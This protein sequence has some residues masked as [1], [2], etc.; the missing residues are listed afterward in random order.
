MQIF[1][2][3]QALQNQ[4]FELKAQ[5]KLI[6]FVPTMG[7]LHAGHLQLI[8][9][10]K[11]SCDVVVCSI[12]VNP[13]Q[14]NDLKDLERYPRNE[15]RDLAL[16]KEKNCDLVFLPSDDLMYQ[17][18]PK[19]K[20]FFPE[21]ENS[22]EGSHRPGH[23]QGVALVVSKLFHIVQAHT[24][25]FGQKDLQQYTIIRQLVAD[26]SFP[27]QLVRVDTVRE[28][29][30]LAMSSRNQR[31]SDHGKELAAQLFTGLHLAKKLILEKRDISYIK[32]EIDFFFSNFAAI[33]LE[34]F[35]LVHEQDLTP[36]AEISENKVYAA[37]IAANIEEVRLIDNIIIHT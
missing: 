7:A 9:E 29:S 22:M 14:F 37:C 3:I 21:L 5:G 33:R 25:F 35:E 26:L 19:L 6:G 28:E 10:A 34:Y 1:R 18:P 13:T 2:E 8:S 23:F 24:A 27:I 17:A 36:A 16:L 4:I 31:L 12:Y 20:I 15:V 32:S 11:K 30:G